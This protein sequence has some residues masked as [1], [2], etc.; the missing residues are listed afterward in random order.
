MNHYPPEFIHYLLSLNLRGDSRGGMTNH[1][2]HRSPHAGTSVEFHDFRSYVPGDDLR[3]ID[4]NIYH[5]HRKL[6]IRRYRHFQEATYRIIID[7][8]ASLHFEQELIHAALQI[9]AAIALVLL[10]HGN[11]VNLFITGEDTPWQLKNGKQDIPRL[12]QK[13][14]NIVIDS[15]S[16]SRIPLKHLRPGLGSHS[17]T[18]AISDFFESGDGES[19]LKQIRLIP[20]TLIPVRIGKAADRNPQLTGNLQLVDCETGNHVDTIVDRSVIREYQRSYDRFI[21]EINVFAGQSGSHHYV[22][23]AA[24][25]DI[26]RTAALFPDGALILN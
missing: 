7:N 12:L 14:N 6:F 8:S 3:R 21:N 18:W 15:G 19:L 17:V 13:L 16:D 5:R 26:A 23:D 2:H 20:G 22:I 4:A 1:G 10:N 24:L 9:A 11:R 25:P